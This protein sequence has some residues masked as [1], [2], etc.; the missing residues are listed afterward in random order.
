MLRIIAS[1]LIIGCLFSSCKKAK[2]DE[3]S[4]LNDPYKDEL[5]T[6]NCSQVPDKSGFTEY[7]K[8][9]V[10]GV[11]ICADIK[12]SLGDTFPNMLVHGVIKRDTGDTYY[13]NLYMVRYTNDAKFM[14]GIFLENT[15]ALTKT[16]PYQLPRDNS[17]LCEIGEV[18]L[19]NQLHGINSSCDFCSSN[20]W[21]YINPF[22]KDRLTLYADKYGNGV[23]EGR[24]SG[25]VSTGSG[26]VATVKNGTFRIRLVEFYKDLK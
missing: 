21:N 14:M 10:N 24:F 8:A 20:K 13:D 6:C 12:R 7:I 25:V 18:Q 22:L 26:R 2:A 5:V 11:T 15:H 3:T 23:F 19:Q 16:F 17:E 4:G 9:E 1:L